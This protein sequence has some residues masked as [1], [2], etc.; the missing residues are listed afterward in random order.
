[1]LLL[2][3]G[4][5]VGAIAAATGLL[6]TKAPSTHALSN[7]AVA[8]VNGELISGDEYQQALNAV[9]QDRKSALD[10]DQRRFVLDR[11]IEQEL[12]LQ[13][14]LDLGIVRTDLRAR[15]LVTSALIASVVAEAEGVQPSDAELM[16]F[17]ERE[18]ALFTGADRVHIRQIWCRVGSQADA[19]P[20]YERAKQAAA[21]LRAGEDFAGVKTALGDTEIAPLPDA[22]LPAAKLG[23]YLGPTAVRTALAL[24]QG[25]VSDPVRSQTGYHVLQVVAKQ[26]GEPPPFEEIKPLVLAEYRRRTAD[27]ALRDY[28]DDL[29]SRAD[30]LVAPSVP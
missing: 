20:A 2:A 18:R 4:A 26:A 12:L 10:D 9:A 25:G 6:D 16:A 27:Q 1:M 7:G 11:L 19:T 8:R 21:R 22:P 5:A 30:I 24:P 17:Y 15:N 13:R 29:R 28:L 23:E 14:A 3:L